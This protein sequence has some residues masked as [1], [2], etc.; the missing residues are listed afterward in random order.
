MKKL[1]PILGIL[2]ACACE[3]QPRTLS[4]QGE[5]MGTTYNVIASDV[6]SG[7]QDADVQSAVEA[8]LAEV[9]AAF[10]NWDP[11]SEVSVINANESIGPIAISSEMAELLKV[12][13]AVHQASEGQFD[14]TL[15]PVIELWGFGAPGPEA[16]IPSDEAIEEAL[17]LTGQRRVLRRDD[18]ARTLEK[19]APKAQIYLASIAKGSGIDAVA[20]TLRGQNLGN[21]MVEIGGDLFAVGEGTTG[22][23]WRIGIEQPDALSRKV[24]RIVAVSGLGMATSG[25]YRNYFEQDGVRYSHIFNAKTGRPV[26]HKT[27]SVTV[28]AENAA[29]ADAWATALL[30]LGSEPGLAIAEAEGLAAFFIDRSETSD[31]NPFVLR[32][33]SAFAALE[34]GH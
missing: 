28:L 1:L 17:A 21:F 18:E 24:E 10:S 14:L 2:I 19:L 32:Q 26:T 9:N 13:D 22:A 5:T 20:E 4:I 27:A 29:L 34:A 31:Q 30:A 33:T 23:G 12:A 7:T 11:T 25:D 3:P 16:E 8:T 15:G 6:P